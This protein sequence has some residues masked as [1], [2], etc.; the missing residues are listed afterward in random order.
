MFTNN[1]KTDFTSDFKDTVLKIRTAVTAEQLIDC[2]TKAFDQVLLHYTNNTKST[3]R[4]SISEILY[5]IGDDMEKPLFEIHGYLMALQR[6]DEKIDI[7][8]SQ[9]INLNRDAE[10]I[11]KILAQVYFRTTKMEIDIQFSTRPW[12]LDASASNLT[13]ELQNSEY[14]K[15]VDENKVLINENAKLKGYQKWFYIFSATTLTLMIILLRD[16]IFLK[17]RF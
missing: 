4:A 1:S 8:K 7:R 9:R 6:A 14:Q 12:R 13:W 17:Y 2:T 10:A 15:M 16:L 5:Y 3:T 11:S